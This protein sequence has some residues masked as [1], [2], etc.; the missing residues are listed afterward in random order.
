M[1]F[2]QPDGAN[3]TKPMNFGTPFNTNGD[4][5][6]LIV[7]LDKINGYFSS[8]GNGGQGADDIFSLHT[9][10]GNLD[11]YFLQKK[12]AL[13]PPTEVGRDA[14]RRGEPRPIDRPGEP[15]VLLPAF[16]GLE[17]AGKLHAG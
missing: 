1:F 13:D 6:G 4:D 7:D 12:R 2:V 5:F 16:P 10:N 15:D 17:I 14:A 8:N 9:E 3:W 11:D